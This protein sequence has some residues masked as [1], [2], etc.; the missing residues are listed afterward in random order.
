MRDLSSAQRA[1]VNVIG[2]FNNIKRRRRNHGHQSYNK[3]IIHVDVVS[4]DLLLPHVNKN[5]VTITFA[6]NFTPFESVKQS[7]GKSKGNAAF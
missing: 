3:P 6:S 1:N 2:L 5:W 4:F 7:S